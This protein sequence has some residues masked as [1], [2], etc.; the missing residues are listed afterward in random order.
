MKTILVTG[1]LGFIFSRFIELALERGYRIVNVD[2]ISYAS[3]KDFKPDSKNYSFI[4]AD[5]KDLKELPHCDYIVHAAS[6]SHVDAS[7]RSSKPFIES[8]VLGT[9]NLLE[10]IKN[11]KI[12]HL[13]AG[14]EFEYPKLVLVS[15]DETFGEIEKGSFGETDQR[16]PGNPYSST[17]AASEMLALG[18][19]KTYKIPLCIT[20]CVN[21]Y[22]PHQ[23]PEKLVP[24]V[25]T[26][27]LNGK[28]VN[29]H[30]NGSYRRCWLFVDDKCDAIFRVMERGKDGESYN[31]GS[32]EEYS[33][34]E[35]VE[36]IAL[37]FNKKL[38][39]V[40]EFVPNRTGQDCRYSLKCDKIQKELGWA[41]KH[42]FEQVIEK[43]V[44]SYRLRLK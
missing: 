28:K 24:H 7:L 27:I 22:G 11:K 44:D 13:E 37:K 5:V 16:K 30:G 34:L 18:W 35:I 12:E 14:L 9:Y 8:N 17:K 19:N 33:V 10:L 42:R 25:I 39:E 20:N 23:H 2:K 3:R 36:K 6:E 1:G 40:V 38:D 41:Q 15:T 43:V 21:I 31:I 4:H 26:Q 32:E 29:V